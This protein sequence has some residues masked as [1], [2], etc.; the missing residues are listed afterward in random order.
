[1]EEMESMFEDSDF[2]QDISKWNISNVKCR[3]NMFKNCPM[4]LKH[5]FKPKI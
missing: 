4:S 1:V 2:E 5:R 3:K